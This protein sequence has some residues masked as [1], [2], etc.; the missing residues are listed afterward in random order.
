MEVGGEDLDDLDSLVLRLM[1]HAQMAQAYGEAI[2]KDP[3]LAR[4]FGQLAERHRTAVRR[5]G[6]EIAQAASAFAG[7]EPA[8]APLALVA[9]MRLH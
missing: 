7:P 6:G 8:R 9:G 1:G 2:R 4:G 3:M 5:L